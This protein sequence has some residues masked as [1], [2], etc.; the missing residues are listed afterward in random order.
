MCL[1]MVW[2]IYAFIWKYSEQRKAVPEIGYNNVIFIAVC[3]KLS[4][5]NSV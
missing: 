5:I 1:A 2:F 4:I 3:L